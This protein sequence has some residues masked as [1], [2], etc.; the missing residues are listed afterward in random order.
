MNRRVGRPLSNDQRVALEHWWHRVSEWL[1]WVNRENR[2][3]REIIFAAKARKARK[4]S[5]FPP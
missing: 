4:S 3:P 5:P 2:N 1:K